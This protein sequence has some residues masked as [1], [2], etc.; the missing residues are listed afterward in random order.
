MLNRLWRATNRS[1]LSNLFGYPTDCPQ[2]EK[3]G[4]TGDAHLAMEVGLF[5]YDV[6]TIYENG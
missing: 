6:I 5:N 1:Y 3:N 2:R 4:W